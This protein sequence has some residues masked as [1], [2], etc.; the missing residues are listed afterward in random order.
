MKSPKRGYSRST[1]KKPRR[2]VQY[3][4]DWVD[5]ALMREVQKKSKRTGISVRSKLMATL[6]RWV[7][8]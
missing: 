1:T 3:L 6:R 2:R 8:T 5:P 4:L 7:R